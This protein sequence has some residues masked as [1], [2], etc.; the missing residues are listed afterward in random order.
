MDVGEFCKRILD[1]GPKLRMK[2]LEDIG[3]P[4]MAQYDCRVDVVVL[5]AI[6]RSIQVR[7]EN[8]PPERF[9]LLVDGLEHVAPRGSGAALGSRGP[10]QRRHVKRVTDCRGRESNPHAAFATQDFKSCAS[11]SFATPASEL[12][13]RC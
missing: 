4:H 13:G 3:G 12:D 8:G 7:C 2:E 6:R 10:D 9:I 5:P 11:A 1:V